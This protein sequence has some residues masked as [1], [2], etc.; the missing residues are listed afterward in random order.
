[1]KK[2]WVKRIS[3]ALAAFLLL[4]VL[5]ISAMAEKETNS[6]IEAAEV[7][8]ETEAANVK[9]TA[10][11]ASREDE[12][13]TSSDADDEDDELP[14]GEI[15]DD[16][17]PV[18]EEEEE[19][20]DDLIPEDPGLVPETEPA[21]VPAEVPEKAASADITGTWT[22]DGITTYRFDENG[23]GELLLPEHTYPFDYTA[24]EEELTLEFDDE[25]IKTA[26]FTFT[27]E[28]DMLILKREEEVG[29]SEFKLE[30]IAD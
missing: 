25:R 22:V 13:A 21:A 19:L 6:G 11:D 5:P 3:I 16:R 8:E 18:E 26:V 24:E 7:V 2:Y 27:V 1:M 17:P 10:A 4:M 20:T 30:K 23:K 15:A 29:T 14:D 9:A 12:V 28:D